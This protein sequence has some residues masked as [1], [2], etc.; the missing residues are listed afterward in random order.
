MSSE[1]YDAKGDL[2]YTSSLSSYHFA[3]SAS[4]TVQSAPVWTTGDFWNTSVSM[5]SVIDPMIPTR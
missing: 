3:E 2:M 1:Q 4:T 5:P